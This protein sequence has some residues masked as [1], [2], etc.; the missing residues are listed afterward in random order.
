MSLAFLFHC[1]MLNMFRMLIHPSSGAYD[2]FVE[3]FHGLYCS[4]SMCVGVTLWFVWGVVVSGYQLNSHY[5]QRYQSVSKFYR[6]TKWTLKLRVFPPP[7]Q[8]KDK[9]IVKGKDDLWGCEFL[10]LA[11]KSA[12]GISCLTQDHPFQFSNNFTSLS[13]P[14]RLSVTT[15]ELKTEP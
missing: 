15:H 7:C 2:L 13:S 4:G 9:I 3:L 12:R 11:N 8:E 14:V 6:I 1:F 10:F 5:A